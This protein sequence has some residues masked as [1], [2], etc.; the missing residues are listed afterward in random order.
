MC[1]EFFEALGRLLDER[2]TGERLDDA[3]KFCGESGE[4]L[5]LFEPASARGTG[6]PKG[7]IVEENV[8]GVRFESRNFH[9][10]EDEVLLRQPF[11]CFQTRA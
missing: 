7:N 1:S 4:R 5:K 10:P 9:L 6:A 2:Q 8:E 3:G 11:E